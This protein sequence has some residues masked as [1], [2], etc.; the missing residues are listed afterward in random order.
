MKATSTRPLQAS[1]SATAWAAVLLLSAHGAWAQGNPALLPDVLAQQ[2]E[3]QAAWQMA[4]AEVERHLLRND[5]AESHALAAGELGAERVVKGAPYCADAVHETVQWL[6]DGSGG[7][8]NRIV[9][10]QTSR[11]CR[12]GEGRTRQ[13]IDRSGRKMVYLRDPVARESWVLDPERKT[14]R[15]LIDGHIAMGAVSGFDAAAMRE[16]SERM[17][18]WARG[19][20]DAAR[21]TAEAARSGAGRVTPPTP[22]T[23]ATS[24][25]LPIPPTPP[26]PPV[27]ATPPAPPTPVLI[28]RS[29]DGQ[30]QTELRVLRLPAGAGSASS[31]WALP[32]PPVQWR[33]R[34]LAPRGAGVVTPLPAKDIEGLRANGERSTWVIEAGQVGNE[35]PIQITR[36]VWTSPELMLTLSSRDFDPRSG[37]LNYRLKALKRGEPEAA[38]MRVPTD[39]KQSGRPANRASSPTG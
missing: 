19:V 9:Q 20:A 13:E 21:G 22:P 4:Q 14:A 35:K 7:A 23:A 15:R 18:D 26:A 2:A 32:P 17:R 29:D 28:T 1:R 37:E 5:G 8:P 11:L 31:E 6:P 25:T 30:R 38:L 12:D 36:E 16:F 33:A 34:S 3:H 27:G 24:P 10:Q 39:F